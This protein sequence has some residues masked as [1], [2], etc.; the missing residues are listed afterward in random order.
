MPDNY[1]PAEAG[2]TNTDMSDIAFGGRIHGVVFF[3]F[4]ADIESHMPVI[5]PK[6]S[7]ISGE[8]KGYPHW[9]PEIV[10]GIRRGLG[11]NG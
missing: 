3:G 8:L 4:G 5:G 7:E 6:L 1:K 11:L 10:P 9:I 2:G